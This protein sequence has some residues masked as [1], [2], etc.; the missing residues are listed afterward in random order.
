M[1]SRWIRILALGGIMVP[2]AWAWGACAAAEGSATAEAGGAGGAFSAVSSSASGDFDTCATASDAAKLVPVNMYIL[3]DK[4]G[5]MAGPKWTQTT[6]AVQAFFS[7]PASA[8][9][10]VALRF[11]PDGGCDASCNVSACSMP[12]VA[13]GELTELSAPTDIH[14][15]ALFDAFE[16]V[17]PS[18]GTPLSAALSGGY[19][20]A[21]G[22]L[23]VHP[24][25]K[26]VVVLVTD[27]EP[28]DC[29]TD[30]SNIASTAASAF[31]E[32]GIITFAIGLE[33]SSTSL[34]TALALKGGS[35]EAIFVDT[36][37]AQEQLSAALGAIR[38]STVACEYIFPDKVDGDDVD[39]AL[40]NM[41]YTPGGASEP[42]T[43]GQVADEAACNPQV[44]G[45]YYDDPVKPK[46]IILCTSTCGAI[47][48]DTAGKIDILF[49][50]SSVPA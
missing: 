8:G 13:L 24:S 49:G 21:E 17:T 36:D 9:L 41:L 45:W 43:I 20:W 33:G 5:S 29:E 16:N 15:Q 30:E 4:S 23:Q 3:F 6:A 35:G 10:R 12:K 18:G 26:A 39:P 7:D 22:V 11:F 48:S 40:V 31:T 32:K 47:R 44:G 19:L 25:E 27:G 37:G 2:L 50:C 38:E 1:A 28:E 34:M 14:E 46:R 42:I